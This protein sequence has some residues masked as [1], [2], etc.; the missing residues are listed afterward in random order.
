[1][2]WL[3]KST[4]TNWNGSKWLILIASLTSLFNHVHLIIGDNWHAL[5]W[6]LFM[7]S[8]FTLLFL[9][10]L[11]INSLCTDLH[12]LWVIDLPS[13]ELA[14]RAALRHPLLRLLGTKHG[15]DHGWFLDEPNG[16]G[17]VAQQ[18]R[19]CTNDYASMIFS[20][21]FCDFKP[22]RS[23][24]HALNVPLI[25]HLVNLTCVRTFAVNTSPFFQ[26]VSGQLL[27]WGFAPVLPNL[28]CIDK[29]KIPPL[30]LII[31][32]TFSWDDLQWLGIINHDY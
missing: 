13:G 7:V 9:Y 14:C 19:N 24:F 18:P 8:Y 22:R 21:D 32:Y 27:Q 6:I 2:D 26:P 16:C 31:L 25:K 5:H 15:S 4:G 3:T 1:M 17:L 10:G 30:C 12:P 20:I 28:R 23:G 11:V 29:W